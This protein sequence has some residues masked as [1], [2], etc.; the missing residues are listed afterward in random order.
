VRSPLLASAALLG[1]VLSLGVAPAV[2]RADPVADAKDLFARGRELRTHGDCAAAAPLFRKAYTLYPAGLGSLRNIAECEEQIGHYA[3]SRRAWLDLKRALLTD[4]DPKYAGWS[5]DAEQAAAR[6]EPKLATLTVEVT[7]RTPDGRAAP[8]RGVDVTLNGETLAPALLG[9]PLERDPGHYV[10]RAAGPGVQAPRESAVDLTAG[11]NRSASL[12]VVVTGAGAGAGAG[13]TGP[14]DRMP[15]ADMPLP[16]SP[17]PDETN[18]SSKRTAAWIAI[19]VGA[20]SLVAMGVSL[21]VRQ[22]ALDDVDAACGSHQGCSPD[23]R[24]TVSR[25]QTASTLVTVF[26]IVG[27]VA[28][29]SGLVLLATSYGHG[30]QA[31]LLLQP[32]MGGVSGRWTF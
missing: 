17:P 8:L 4:G 26:S 2:A 25:G 23:L 22:A 12:A 16:V 15:D 5:Q 9:T 24:S 14:A 30:Q 29:T 31:A 27:G 3:S 1:A 20:A 19:G 21:G 7:A 11:V 18:G 13:A 10:V 6:L 28:L 32:A